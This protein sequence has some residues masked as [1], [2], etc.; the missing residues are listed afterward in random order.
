MPLFLVANVLE[1]KRKTYLKLGE[2]RQ[3][4]FDVVRVNRACGDLRFIRN[5]LLFSKNRNCY[6]AF[7]CSRNCFLRNDFGADNLGNYFGNFPEQ[8]S[9]SGYVDCCFFI[10]G[11]T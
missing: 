3:K 7:D 6:A 9:R 4:T 1:T 2:N 11:W 8:N 10:I 5:R